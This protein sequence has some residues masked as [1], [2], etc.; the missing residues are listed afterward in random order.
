MMKFLHDK[1][2][3]SDKRAESLSISFFFNARGHLL[4]KSV[5]GM[6]RSLLLQLLE[7]FTDLQDVLDDI[8]IETRDQN[9]C[10]PVDVLKD[11]FQSAVFRLGK[12]SL[13]SFVDALDEGDEQQIIEMVQFFEDIAEQS[14]EK[15]I[16]FRTCLSSRH[17]PYIDVRYGLRLTMEHQP[18]HTEDLSDYIRGNLRVKDAQLL[19]DLDDQLVEKSRGVFLW[20][21]LVVDI[22]NAENRR[23]RLA[24]KKRLAEIPAGL[25]DLFRDILGRDRNNM[26]DLFL[27]ISWILF[28]KRPLSPLEYHHAIWAGLAMKDLA[29]DDVPSTA[30]EDAED[31]AQMCVLSSSKGL[32]E[33]TK[34]KR[35]VVQFIHESV[36]D[37]LIKD[38]GL[39]ELWPDLGLDWE[40]Q[41]HESLKQCCIFYLHHRDISRL[42]REIPGGDFI[43]VSFKATESL[44]SEASLLEYAIRHLLSHAE[45]AAGSIPQGDVLTLFS[46]S[47]WARLLNMNEMY[48]IRQYGPSTTLIYILADRGLA[49]L[50]RIQIKKEPSHKKEEGGATRYRYPLFATLA[51]GN[52]DAVAAVLGTDVSSSRYCDVAAAGLQLKEG[53]WHAQHQQRTP[54]S[55]AASEGLSNAISLLLKQGVSVNELDRARAT[56]LAGAIKGGHHTAAQLLI[57]NGAEVTQ[58]I[59]AT[60]VERAAETGNEP[61]IKLLAHLGADMN[62]CGQSNLLPRFNYGGEDD[63]YPLYKAFSLGHER[64]AEVMVAHGAFL[65]DP[66][67]IDSSILSKCKSHYPSMMRILSRDQK[68]PDVNI[69][70]QQMLLFLAT[71]LG[72]TFYVRAYLKTGVIDVNWRNQ[73]GE[74]PLFIASRLGWSDIVEALIQNNADIEARAR[75]HVTPISV[76]SMNGHEDVV[77]LLLTNGAD[78]KTA[79]Y[80]L[81]TAAKYGCQTAVRELIANGIDVNAKDHAEDTPLLLA[82]AASNDAMVALLLELGADIH[83]KDKDKQTSLHQAC[84]YNRCNIA[85]LLVDHGSNVNANDRSGWTPL[86][87]A[88]GED[89]VELLLERGAHVD[90]RDRHDRTPLHLAAQKRYWKHV[91]LLIRAGANV[92]ARDVHQETPLHVASHAANEAVVEELSARKDVNVNAKNLVRQTPLYF[93][94]QFGFDRIVNLL[95]DNGADPN[96]RDDGMAQSCFQI[97]V[98]N[99]HTRIVKILLERGKVDLNNYGRYDIKPLDKACELG[100][101][102]L[103]ELLLEHGATVD[104]RDEW[105]ERLLSR[106]RSFGHEEIAKLLTQYSGKAARGLSLREKDS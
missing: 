90:A 8:D 93:A 89:T 82:A 102:E 14:A 83:A 23:G 95:I 35:Q 63:S 105:V 1:S 55:W 101:K 86:H 104:T 3:K 103:V 98:S 25:S 33:V 87:V 56:P 41:S 2:R 75:G 99:A 15:G 45:A 92:N 60:G 37:Y 19:A 71:E 40:A 77:R 69:K 27:S 34:T 79:K 85:K 32:A 66:S 57:D 42:I 97:A 46:P 50:I 36:R 78:I 6:Y 16:R 52:E 44:R 74:T 38:R 70:N 88:L 26:E 21:K 11:L 30:A 20:I 96:A 51:R 73:L 81:H 31:C 61:L 76:S 4:E 10:P 47:N 94:C 54:L 65:A 29:D 68:K 13:T 91:V 67:R 64:V 49:N 58:E 24:L 53:E 22:L 18:G 43:E 39:N 7:R 12:R 80:P 59:L 100:S 48:K 62:A 106:A 72:L 17:Y 28:A 5:S 9:E 84:K